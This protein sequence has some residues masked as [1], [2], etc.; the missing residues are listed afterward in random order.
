M[1]QFKIHV[2]EP[3]GA[4]TV[5]CILTAVYKNAGGYTKV[6][7]FLLIPDDK[8]TFYA[9]ILDFGDKA[10]GEFEEEF[11]L[12]EALTHAKR[13][14]RQY[15]IDEELIQVDAGFFRGPE[16]HEDNVNL[17]AHYRIRGTCANQLGQVM[18]KT[19]YEP[20]RDAIHNTLNF[21][22]LRVRKL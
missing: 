16:I 12:D 1:P 15:V 6:E 17:F 9:E 4:G 18:D 7:W 19:S 22:P 14:L 5:P 13:M 10:G 8:D 11:L 20:L 2:T 3:L 21:P